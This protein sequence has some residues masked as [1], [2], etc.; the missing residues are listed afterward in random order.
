MI[1]DFFK[2]IVEVVLDKSKSFGFK[3]ALFVSVIG[4][5]FIVDCFFNVSYNFHVSNK[6]TNLERVNVLKTYYQYDS[7]QMIRLFEIES[8]L[9][10]RKHY[11]EFIT[12]Q[13]SKIELKPKI[14]D[15][16]NDQIIKA[17]KEKRSTARSRFWM[18]FTSNYL[19]I[20]LLP[21]I[22][23]LPLF[24]KEKILGHFI[25][26]WFASIVFLSGFIIITSWI[27]FQI[28]VIFNSP[29]WNYFLNALIHTFFIV[30]VVIASKDKKKN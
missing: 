5:I 11:S 9:L 28:P 8:K 13:L 18:I 2:T 17:K 14:E 7:L 23:F 12:S 16:E 26:G 10:N 3:T 20:V 6:L 27:A 19:L 25:L 1:S 30:V 15:L 22:L 24:S 4:A 21:I 29:I